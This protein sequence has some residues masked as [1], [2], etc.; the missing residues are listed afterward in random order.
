[1]NKRGISPLIA[2]VLLVAFVIT[3]AVLV[4]TWWDQVVKERAAK[5]G[6]ESESQISCSLQIDFQV[7][8]I[9]FDAVTKFISFSV[10]NDGDAPLH[11]FKVRI[12]GEDS[13]GEKVSGV[14]SI[15]EDVEEGSAKKTA[16]AYDSS[17]ITSIDSLEIIPVIRA[18]GVEAVCI[19]KSVIVKSVA[20]C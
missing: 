18:K 5:V 12:E 19:E 7:K 16:V 4:F 9:C 3:L 1:M 2:T 15:S 8:D 6:A 11:G 10:E 13:S 14:S 20:V 17:I